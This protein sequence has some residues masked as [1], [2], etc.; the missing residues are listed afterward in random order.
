[1]FIILV[2]Q[3]AADFSG[4]T[5]RVDAE[6]YEVVGLCCMNIVRPHSYMLQKL[7]VLFT[8]SIF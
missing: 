8:M 6:D 1:M 2:L 4:Q 7:N 5:K 3:R